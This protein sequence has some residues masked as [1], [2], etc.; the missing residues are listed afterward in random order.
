[1]IAIRTRVEPN[2][3]LERRYNGLYQ[4]YRELYTA[5]AP[6]YRRLPEIP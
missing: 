5:L 4:Q 1:L 6:V 3:A 2:P